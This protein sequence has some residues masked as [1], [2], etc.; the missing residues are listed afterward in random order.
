MKVIYVTRNPDEVET[1]D[2]VYAQV[3]EVEVDE[4]AQVVTITVVIKKK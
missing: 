4:K 2:D 1:S 3:T